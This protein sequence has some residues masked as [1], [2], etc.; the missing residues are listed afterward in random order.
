MK[1]C[2]ISYITSPLQMSFFYKTD[3]DLLYSQLIEYFACLGAVTIRAYRL[4]KSFIHQNENKV[5]TNQMAYYPN[6]VS[7][8]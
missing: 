3:I 7:N 1:L 2:Y 6:I 4:Q 5:D 8:R